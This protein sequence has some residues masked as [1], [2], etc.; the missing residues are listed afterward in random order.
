M[1]YQ[2]ISEGENSHEF[3]V[4]K[5]FFVVLLFGLGLTTIYYISTERRTTMTVTKAP[6]GIP[7]IDLAA[8]TRTETATFSLG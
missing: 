6:A 5:I 3:W 7:P 2:E 4:R 8:P 1:T